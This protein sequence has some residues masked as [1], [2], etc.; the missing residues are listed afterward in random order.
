LEENKVDSI[1]SVSQFLVR[2]SSRQ[3]VRPSDARAGAVYERVI[4]DG[5]RYFVKRLSRASDW[6]MRIVGDR[7]HRP[8]VA[9]RAGLMDRSTACVDHAIVAM[10]VAGTGD[11]AVLTMVM[12]DVAPS[13]VPPGDDIVP[14][15]H[16]EAF[17][18]GMAT[19]SSLF[20]GW[21]D[22]IGLMSMA[23]R[24]RML[25]PDNIAGELAADTVPGPVAAAAAGWARLAER[26]PAL[27]AIT[28]LVH[29]EPGIVSVPMRGTP[30]TFL[31]GDWK[32]GNLGVHP[33]GRVVLLDWAFPGSGPPLWDLCWYLA[34][35]RAR[36]PEPKERAIDRY[37]SALERH[38]VSTSGWWL[39]QLDLCMI[40]VMA[41]FGW[42]K[43]LG[44]ADELSWWDD[45]V[46]AAADRL[47]IRTSRSVF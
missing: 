34:L 25:A 33:D 30:C 28:R 44:D 32:M 42:E 40:G 35:N 20:W 10:D 8:F 5:D 36:M 39:E 38:G 16:H 43:A 15:R 18:T 17:V 45:T 29:E 11:D 4:V 3:E 41:T 23:Q 9:W 13:L 37:R 22:E 2:A 19:L 6:I 7:V 1:G 26:A 46:A 12:R 27:A 14:A 24:L 21:R 31:Q 47:G